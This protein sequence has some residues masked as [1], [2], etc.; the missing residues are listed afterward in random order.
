MKNLILGVLMAFVLF[1]CAKPTEKKTSSQDEKLK[2]LTVNYPLFYFAERIGGELIDLNYVIPDDVDPAFWS[3]DEAAL[4]QYQKVDII[5]KNGADYAKWM[6]NVSLPSSRIINTAS[7]FEKDLLKL[8]NTT[9]HNH[10][11]EGEHEH[12]GKAFTVWLD[13]EL[14][15]KQAEII[16]AQLVKKI[17]GQSA[18]IDQ[19]FEKLKQ[20]L[21]SLHKELLDA[22]KT[23]DNQVII[24]SHPVYQYLSRAYNLSLKSVHF[25]PNEYPSAKQWENLNNLIKENESSVMLWEDEPSPQIQIELDKIGISSV[26]F[27]PCG[28]K[29][30]EGDFLSI[31]HDNLKNIKNKLP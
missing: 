18:L 25:E 7:S 23:F 19:N 30:S 14:A 27:N 10:G 12:D 4:S 3:P 22:T 20:D 31:M 11:P 6:N 16:R 21:L 5:F 1:S 24:G 28:N 2:V 15:L 17:P 26:V 29:P 8:N 9:S 13:L